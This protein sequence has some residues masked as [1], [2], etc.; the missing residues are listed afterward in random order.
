V[1]KA[2]IDYL[3]RLYATIANLY[4][5][6]FV[7]N[8]KQFIRQF[9]KRDFTAEVTNTYM[10][11]FETYF[12]HYSEMKKESKDSEFLYTILEKTTEQIRNDLPKKF[13]LQ[14]IIQLLLFE[15]FLFKYH[16]S[17][18][19]NSTQSIE[20]VLLSISNNLNILEIDYLNCKA[21]IF[22]K[23]LDL[24][25][26]KDL[27]ILA[28]KKQFS[29]NVNFIEKNNFSGQV[30][31]LNIPSINSI[32]FYYKGS[33]NIRLNNQSI[34]PDNIYILPKGASIKS[35]Q[36]E[37]V[38]YNDILRK[39]LSD[40]L[41][42]LHFDI[43][44]LEFKF[45]N[46]NNGIHKLTISL[47]AGQL[48]GIIGRSGV[49]KSTLLSLL[50]GTLPPQ[51][52]CVLINNY[53]LYE[54]KSK[55]DGLIGYIPQD[56][57]LVEELTVFE[58][59]YLSSRLCLGNLSDQEITEKVYT[60]LID[61]DLYEICNLKVGTPLNKFISG[62]QR[63][64]L[65]IAL[66][67]IREPWILFA[68]E[69]TSGLS[70]SDADDIMQLFIDQ[71]IKSRIVVM[72]IH[73]PSS[74]AFKLFDKIL[75]LDKEGYP[76]F[77]GNPVDSID[78]FNEKT[79]SFVR[80][81]DNCS[82]CGNINHEAIFRIIEERRVDNFGNYTDHR[83]ISPSKWHSFFLEEIEK[84]KIKDLEK[85]EIPVVKFKKPNKIGQLKIFS[86][87]NILSKLANNQ[88][89]LLSLLVSP[90]LALL[91]TLL[92]RSGVDTGGQNSNYIFAFNQNIPAYLFMSVIVALFV[93]LI[94]SAEEI[95]K[96]RK[97][98]K[99]EAFLK[100]DKKSYLL[101]KISFLFFLSMVQT[102]LFVLIGNIILGVKGMLLI[103][104]IILFSTSCFANVL[105]LLIS[106]AFN[107]VVVIYILVPILIVPQ[108]LLSGVVV[109]YD[110]LN[111]SFVSQENVPLV[112]DLMASRWAYEAM[113]VSQFR[114]NAYQK[115]YVALEMEESNTKFD[116][117]FV[118]PELKKALG[119][120][121]QDSESNNEIERKNDLSFIRN[122]LFKL[123]T[124]IPFENIDG[125]IK[126]ELS[127]QTWTEI[128]V[129]LNYVKKILQNRINDFNL[130]KDK[131]T[132]TLLEELG[133]HES[134][135]Y[136]KNKHHNSKLAEIVLNRT[137]FE[138][139]IK[140]NN[141]IIRKIEPIYQIPDSKVGR[142]HFFSSIKRIGDLEFCT[143]FFNLMIIWL[144]TIITSFLL[145]LLFK[146]KTL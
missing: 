52:G 117:L 78:Y 62:G 127:N 51:K 121:R 50:N 103:Y 76:I 37:P 94:I 108:L 61:M 11:Q 45:K 114:Y 144:M 84:S 24:S 72:N 93:G 7:E 15:K 92:C 32:L 59:L 80:S 70:S 90:I 10:V 115:N 86:K 104:W 107:S 79:E 29:I 14:I 97:I 38:Y 8:I 118:V 19:I 120:L 116:L 9:L 102:F 122:E 128:N 21:F 96:D 95:Y 53:N 31:F 132:H 16:P 54:D 47:E 55:L 136:Y 35:E 18:A 125:I 137:S 98:L 141:K 25:N 71:T 43:N 36:S 112:G 100:L 33:N 57:L 40:S 140:Q 131:I 99:R 77:F 2:L 56:D 60:L 39:F 146:N 44:D 85:I 139:F 145:Y 89:I 27:L 42:K 4:P 30:Y 67:L 111:K 23:L 129:Y 65:N 135:S 101:S 3:I 34:F 17:S 91:L 109:Q 142:A 22:E 81:S 63:K 87:R 106:T 13:R 75:V 133:D 130:K 138:T 46:S 119:A 41:H 49:G 74:D 58:N 113:V 73:Q 48:V 6:V 110:Q 88:Y 105:G 20:S 82:N 66:E 69:P 123:N 143:L 5:L 64:R 28:N 126:N 12:Q 1:N 68:D 26:K 134:F 124:K 83:K